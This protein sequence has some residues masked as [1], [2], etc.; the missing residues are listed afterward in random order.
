MSKLVPC[1]ACARHLRARESACPFCGV[2]RVPSAA[3]AQDPT[4]RLG[5]AALFAFALT[6]AACGNESASPPPTTVAPPSSL[7]PPPTAIVQPYGAPVFRDPEPPPPTEPPSTEPAPPA[8]GTEPQHARPEPRPSSIV[9][10][11]GAPPIR[12]PTEPSFE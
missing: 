1:E 8:T 7:V 6:S 11:Y 3:E 2:S 12:H 4:V 9:H 5:R 10:P